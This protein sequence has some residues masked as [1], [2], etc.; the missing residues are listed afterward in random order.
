MLLSFFWKAPTEKYTDSYR[1][2]FPM[3][4]PNIPIQVLMIAQ[5]QH[6]ANP[7]APPTSI[8]KLDVFSYGGAIDNSRG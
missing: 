7:V 8:P 6:H 3:Q 2:P 4:T 5:L 1:L